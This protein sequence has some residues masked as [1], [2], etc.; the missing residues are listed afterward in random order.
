[1]EW[2]EE[3]RAWVNQ[4]PFLKS[5]HFNFISEISKKMIDKN[6]FLLL[7]VPASP[8][9]LSVRTLCCFFIGYH[10]N[11]LQVLESGTLIW[12]N[13]NKQ[14]CLQNEIDY[15]EHLIVVLFIS[16]SG[17]ELTLCELDFCSNLWTVACGSGSRAYAI[18]FT[19]KCQNGYRPFWK[20]KTF[21]IIMCCGSRN[22]KAHFVK[23]LNAQ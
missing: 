11:N 4:I 18:T 13:Q 6:R 5:I 17:F 2:V 9:A 16:S 23:V 8:R 1:M 20:M 7:A 15:E 10:R 3:V 22:L 14:F 21:S 12:Q 19:E